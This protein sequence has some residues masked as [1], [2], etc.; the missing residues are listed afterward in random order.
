MKKFYILLIALFISN[1]A[2][3][4]WG[5]SCLPEG[6]TFTNQAQIDSFQVN[7]PGCIEIKGD[8]YL[9]ESDITSLNGL[10]V[11]TAIGGGLYIGSNTGLTSL[12]GLEGLTSIGWG[13]V[14]G[15]YDGGGNAALTSLTGLDNIEAGSI[16][17]LYVINNDSLSTCAV[18][19]ICDYLAS[20]NGT[21]EIHDNAPG[22]NSEEE[23]KEACNLTGVESSVSSQQSAV[24][25]FP[26][27][28]G[29][30]VNLQFTVYNLQSISLKIYDVHG[31]EVAV[32]V[33]GRWPGG[34]VVKGSGDQVVRW[35][36]SGLPAGVYY[37][38]LTTKDQ[39]PTTGKIV[40]Y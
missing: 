31:R 3:A 33:N 10:R 37:Y 4:Q 36:A 40:K 29:G 16:T 11:L 18:Q 39:R 14:I 5:C 17:E 22:C 24:T 28:T 23:V 27:P 25:C 2:R 15:N 34:Q 6:I 19:S 38:R 35:D 13:L 9:Y 21:F 12:T 26:N 30:M 8:V 7:Y 32:V 20:P 1:G